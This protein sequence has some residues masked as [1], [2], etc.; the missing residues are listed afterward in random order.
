M[1]TLFVKHVWMS[2]PQSHNRPTTKEAKRL[3]IIGD[4][5]CSHQV[6]RD[7]I[8]VVGRRPSTKLSVGN[9]VLRTSVIFIDSLVALLGRGLVVMT[10]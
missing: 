1:S 4:D 8:H 7:A 3:Q 9:A 10:G 6:C 5:Q 2:L